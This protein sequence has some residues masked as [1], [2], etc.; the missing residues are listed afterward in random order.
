VSTARPTPPALRAFVRETLGCSCPDSVFDAVER[1]QEVATLSRVPFT[2]WVIGGRPLVY[3]A[4]PTDGFEQIA[5]ELALLGRRDRDARGLNRFR[6]VLASALAE[7]DA[8]AAERAFAKAAGE[9][10]KAHLHCV[11]P[12]RC[13]GLLAAG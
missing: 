9:D 1:T 7:A 6:L 5:V 13:E 4:S 8:R 10:A 12:E 11:A 2:R 3:V